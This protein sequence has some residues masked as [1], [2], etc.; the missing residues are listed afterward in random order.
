MRALHQVRF[1]KDIC[2]FSLPPADKLALL[3]V[4]LGFAVNT[5]Q[6]GI[7]VQYYCR[8][9]VVL[10]RNISMTLIVA[11]MSFIIRRPDKYYDEVSKK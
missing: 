5:Y 6:V 2:G 4:T 11:L 7:F 8:T 3:N 1:S 10:S 9:I